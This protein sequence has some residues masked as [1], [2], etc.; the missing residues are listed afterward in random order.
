MSYAAPCLIYAAAS[1]IY[2]APQI[3]ATPHSD[4]ELRRTLVKITI[5]EKRFYAQTVNCM[6]WYRTEL[7][8]GTSICLTC[9]KRHRCDFVDADMRQ[10]FSNYI[11]YFSSSQFTA[12]CI[13]CT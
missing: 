9:N 13:Y 1:H 6:V 8:E 5:A 11:T 10:A 7:E 2:A 3:G 12:Y 4:S